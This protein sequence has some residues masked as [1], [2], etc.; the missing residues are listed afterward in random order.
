MKT[1]VVI[2]LYEHSILQKSI[3]YIKMNEFGATPNSLIINLAI[4]LSDF[5]DG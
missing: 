2:Y 4:S 1:A 3:Q 5:F